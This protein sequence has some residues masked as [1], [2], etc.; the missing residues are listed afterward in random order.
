MDVFP[1]WIFSG[2]APGWSQI[3]SHSKQNNTQ[4]IAITLTFN[5]YLVQKIQILGKPCI[6]LFFCHPHFICQSWVGLDWNGLAPDISSFIF[7]SR[8]DWETVLK[9]ERHSRAALKAEKLPPPECLW[10]SRLHKTWFLSRQIQ[11]FA[12]TNPDFRGEKILAFEGEIWADVDAGGGQR[13]HLFDHKR[14]IHGR[15]HGC[16][17]QKILTC[18][19]HVG[20]LHFVV[21]RQ[22]FM[23]SSPS[24]CHWI[25]QYKFDNN[26][27]IGFEIT[28][29]TSKLHCG[30]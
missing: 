4:I 24:K 28:N 30:A 14:M 16:P 26:Y 17:F 22:T 25:I 18:Q 13:A 19:I 20:H 2:T 11:I 3:S 10:H 7:I 21:L 1:K 29:L 9:R 23:H 8:L 5:V 27:A 12:A 6:W 15:W